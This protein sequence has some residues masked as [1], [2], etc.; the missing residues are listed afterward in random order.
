MAL[1]LSAQMRL[2]SPFS[3]LLAARGQTY[4]NVSENATLNKFDKQTW[5]YPGP[6]RPYPGGTLWRC[7]DPEVIPNAD[8]W[9]TEPSVKEDV[10]PEERRARETEGEESEQRTEPGPE[11]GTRSEKEEDDREDE[12]IRGRHEQH[13]HVPGG[14][15]LTQVRACL[16]VNLLPEWMRVGKERERERASGEPGRDREEGMEERGNC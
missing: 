3:G 8:I 10:D 1:Q 14:A 15:R 7:A 2:S 16:R 5:L 9:D 4:R 13:R 11:G 12:E 6:A